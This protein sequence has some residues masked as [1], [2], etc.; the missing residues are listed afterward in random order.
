MYG[1]PL[2]RLGEKMIK[3]AR[4]L[5]AGQPVP[6]AD[7][8]GGVVNQW[9]RIKL[10]PRMEKDAAGNPQ[11]FQR[12]LGPGGTVTMKWPPIYQPTLDE[13]A[14]AIDAMSRGVLNNLIDQET[15]V[16]FVARFLGVEAVDKMI[17]KIEAERAQRDAEAQ[18]QMAQAMG[19][20]GGPPG[21][22]GVLTR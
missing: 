18:Q 10:P 20:A 21:G 17:K 16:R 13:I 11:I 12:E 22:G 4:L 3:A 14:K 8:E 9:S 6:A 15:A 19:G 2:V 5:A 7:V 1:G